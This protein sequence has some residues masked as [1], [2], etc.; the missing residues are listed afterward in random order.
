[1]VFSRNDA[2]SVHGHMTLFIEMTDTVKKTLFIV[3]S[4]P[5]EDS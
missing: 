1:M 3:N 5:C 2:K 4:T